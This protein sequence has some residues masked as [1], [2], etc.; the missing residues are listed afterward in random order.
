MDGDGRARLRRAVQGRGAVIGDPILADG[1]CDA[2]LIIHHR[3]DIG[4]C[5]RCGEGR[6][7]TLVAR[8]VSGYHRKLLAV[9]L[10]RRKGRNKVTVAVSGGAA[11]H[12]AVAVGD[13][14]FAAGSAVPVTRVP[15]GLMAITGSA[16]GVVS[17]VKFTGCDSAL[18]L[19]AASVCLMVIECGP[20]ASGLSGL[21]L[22]CR[23]A[24]R[25]FA[26]SA[27]RCHRPDCAAGSPVPPAVVQRSQ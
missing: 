13:D 18:W 6:R 9:C 3:E 19:P 22:R 21:R 2:G 20:S 26:Q 8:R 11:N 24:A 7:R 1:A 23:L 4:C 17:T 10:C 16:G 27:H 14:D 5:V 25:W 12:V 15:T